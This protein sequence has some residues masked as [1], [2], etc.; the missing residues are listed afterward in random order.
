MTSR[1]LLL[2]LDSSVLIINSSGEIE[3]HLSLRLVTAIACAITTSAAYSS[4]EVTTLVTDVG[5]YGNG[6]VYVLL[7]KTI[8]E[9]G[10]ARN[11][12]EFPANAVNSKVVLATALLAMASGKAVVVRT[13]TC[14]MGNPSLNSTIRQ[15]YF[16]VTH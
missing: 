9:S 6:N 12:V 2:Y 13:D 8:D 14:F 5:T 10:C 16:G 3:M 11:A 15:G 4:S 1:L 7:E